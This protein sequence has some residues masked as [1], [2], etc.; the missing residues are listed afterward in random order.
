[1]NGS[2]SFSSAAARASWRGR[3]TQLTAEGR[4]P[5]FRPSTCLLSRLSARACRRGAPHPTALSPQEQGPS[6]AFLSTR[7]RWVVGLEAVSLRQWSPLKLCLLAPF[8]WQTPPPPTG[9]TGMP[10]IHSSGFGAASGTVSLLNLQ[11]QSRKARCLASHITLLP[12]LSCSL[13]ESPL[14]GA[15]PG[16]PVWDAR[17]GAHLLPRRAQSTLGTVWSD[18]K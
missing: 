13:S 3:G 12:V 5:P 14:P 15:G 16:L 18:C 8:F 17:P 6:A 1:M 7:P 4:A 9:T 10:G 11:D 2:C